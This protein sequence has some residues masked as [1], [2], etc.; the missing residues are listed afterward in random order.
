M[1][2]GV[3]GGKG[4]KVDLAQPFLK[5]EVLRTFFKGGI[6]KIDIEIDTEMI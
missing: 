5:V 1:R 3:K 6:N 4:G 2:T